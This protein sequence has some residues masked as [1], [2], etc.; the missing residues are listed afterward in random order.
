MAR[1]ANVVRVVGEV[2]APTATFHGRAG[3]FIRLLNGRLK[4][5]Y[6]RRVFPG[7]LRSD[8]RRDEAWPLSLGTIPR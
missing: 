6:P 1:D 4:D 2:A 7:Y 3:A 5:P 8:P